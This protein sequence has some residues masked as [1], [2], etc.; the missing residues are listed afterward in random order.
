M[1]EPWL[2]Y[3]H[4]PARPLSISRGHP[5]RSV[6]PFGRPTALHQ[7]STRGRCPFHGQRGLPC[8]RFRVAFRAT[9]KQTRDV[10][11]VLRPQH[12]SW[13]PGYN[14]GPSSSGGDPWKTT[15]LPPTPT[16]PPGDEPF[17]FKVCA[18]PAGALH[19]PTIA[20]PSTSGDGRSGVAPRVMGITTVEVVIR[21]VR[22][23]F[24][25]CGRQ[26]S[27]ELTCGPWMI[28]RP[29]R[30]S[31]RVTRVAARFSA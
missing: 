14:Q 19:S 28:A 8:W 2:H 4:L 3:S 20:Y 25:G 22:H 27:H 24:A 18:S 7:G 12:S 16:R 15:S 31:P 21:S 26:I 13:L 17:G 30:C 11:C 10:L 9:S 29:R 6:R 1:S 5:A 23:Q